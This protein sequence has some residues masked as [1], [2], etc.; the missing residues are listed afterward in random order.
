MEQ[1]RGLKRSQIEKV[2]RC[3]RCGK[4]LGHALTFM[5]LR[6]DR[7]M[8]NH[9]AIQRQHG[10]ELVVGNAAIAQALGPDEE[11]AVAIVDRPVE[12]GVCQD[13]TIE[14]MILAGVLERAL[15]LEEKE[16]GD[17]AGA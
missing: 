11:L 4:K 8:F 10:L 6:L 15:E 17:V 12:V 9:R 13:C 1:P 5:V 3:I 7:F 16:A 2:I 14:P